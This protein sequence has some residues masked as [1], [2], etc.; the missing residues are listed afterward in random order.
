LLASQLD[1]PSPKIISVAWL[2]ALTL[3]WSRDWSNCL[4]FL[5]P[6]FIICFVGARY[7]SHLHH[8]LAFA[9]LSQLWH[10]PIC[11]CACVCAYVCVCVCVCVCVLL[12]RT[13]INFK[14]VCALCAC[15]CA[16]T[17]IWKTQML[18]WLLCAALWTKSWM[19]PS[20]GEHTIKM[21]QTSSCM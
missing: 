12:G 10:V 18:G 5:P 3:L 14:C 13:G 17:Q 16:H 8:L 11:V 19:L 15:R 4:Y 2:A 21:L 20:T 1:V 7:V 6:F 9:L